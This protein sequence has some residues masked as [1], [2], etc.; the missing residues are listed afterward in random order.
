MT[1]TEDAVD[2]TLASLPR[3]TLLAGT[4]PHILFA[5]T[6]AVYDRH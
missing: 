5:A 6:C 2:A 3:D 4:H 1:A